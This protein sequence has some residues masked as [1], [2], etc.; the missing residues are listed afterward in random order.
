MLKEDAFPMP[1]PGQFTHKLEVVCELYRRL[2]E[3]DALS[4][5][6]DRLLCKP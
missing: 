3:S 2:D 6:A 4:L 1:N 5:V